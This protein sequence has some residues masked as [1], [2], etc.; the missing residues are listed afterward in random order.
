M[1]CALVASDKLRVGSERP[2]RCS[3]RFFNDILF[4]VL[5][6][7][8]VARLRFLSWLPSAS[9]ETFA[10]IAKPSQV[11]VV[12]LVDFGLN[13]KSMFL[14]EVEKRIEFL[15]LLLGHVIP[16]FHLSLVRIDIHKLVRI[17]LLQSVFISLNLLS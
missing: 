16:L 9:F 10:L 7:S 3:F 13:V 5:H 12:N 17:R 4:I 15:E 1:N 6:L 2:N 8:S 11:N 14:G